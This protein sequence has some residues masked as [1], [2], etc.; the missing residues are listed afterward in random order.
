[1]AAFKEHCQDCMKELGDEYQYVHHWLDE[2]FHLLGGHHRKIRHHVEGVEEARKLWGDRAAKAA[3]I[4]IKK[5]NCGRVPYSK[6]Y[7]S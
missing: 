4:H 6:E 2:Y 7:E 1:M 5:D 3:E